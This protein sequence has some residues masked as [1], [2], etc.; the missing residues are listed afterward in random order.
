[1]RRA[2]L[3]LHVDGGASPQLP[4]EH[5]LL[6]SYQLLPLHLP[7]GLQLLLILL[8]L[9]L[10]REGGR[11]GGRGGG[12]RRVNT[13]GG[14][15]YVRT[16]DIVH[17]STHR[18]ACKQSNSCKTIPTLPQP[19][20]KP[21]PWHRP[22]WP[23][24]TGRHVWAAPYPP[25]MPSHHQ[26]HTLTPPAGVAITIHTVHATHTTGGSSAQAAVLTPPSTHDLI[27]T[28]P[29]ANVHV[30]WEQH[31]RVS[32]AP[33]DFTGQHTTLTYTPSL[34]TSHTLT[35]HIPHPHSSLTCIFSNLFCCSDCW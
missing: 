21:Y 22:S 23:G 18:L 25:H 8:S 14:C 29:A 33:L 3:C 31:A 11:E 17:I 26:T 19:W 32:R 12:R 7:M 9:G 1:M 2:H 20:G 16:Q 35:P 10:W 13:P 30:H 15:I 4:L 5:L 24:L 6:L 34:L 28:A 27:S